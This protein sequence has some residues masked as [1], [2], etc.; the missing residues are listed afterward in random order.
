MSSKR[1]SNAAGLRRDIELLQVLGVH[2]AQSGQGLGVLRI[3]ALAGREKTQVSRALSTL[4]EQGLVDR[5]PHT[6]HYRLGW[7]LYALS[8]QTYEA[9][10]VSV[11]T[12]FLR[13]VAEFTRETTHLCVLRQDEVL[14][15]AT[16][17]PAH[18]FRA[19]WE[20]LF[21]PAPTTSAGRVLLSEWPESALREKWTGEE[22]Q[23]AGGA[24]HFTSTDEFL[25]VLAEIR[26]TGY[27]IVDEEFELGVVGCSAPVRDPG[28]RIIAVINV[29][30]P[31]LRLG[32]QLQQAAVI[33]RKAAREL[34]AALVT[35]H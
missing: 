12:P 35:P 5:D 4:A 18:G 32:P 13:R 33:T 26:K 10:L 20:G 3:A 28:G 25:A 21:S 24:R 1:Q 7:R 8:A 22:L 2:Q 19:M 17:S 14:T 6:L 9:H 34:S 29:G 16:Q 11:A 31:K 23:A 15:L 30:A 27:S